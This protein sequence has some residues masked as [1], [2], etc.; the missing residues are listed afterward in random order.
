MLTS[1]FEHH[2][3]RERREDADD[4]ILDATWVLTR[5]S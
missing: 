3:G 2:I 4:K 1:L 5:S